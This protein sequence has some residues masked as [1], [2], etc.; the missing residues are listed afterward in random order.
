MT[1]D[2]FF[3]GIRYRIN[4][5]FRGASEKVKTGN[6]LIFARKENSRGGGEKVAEERWSAPL[7]KKFILFLE[8]YMRHFGRFVS[9]KPD[10]E[11]IR[12]LLKDGGLK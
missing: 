7:G 2:R 1:S 3:I 8:E 4:E 12:I 5:I 6:E 11:A 9:P 10:D